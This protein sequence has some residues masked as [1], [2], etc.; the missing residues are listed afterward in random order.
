[1]ESSQ[2]FDTAQSWTLNY[3]RGCRTMKYTLKRDE[4]YFLC[5]GCSVIISNFFQNTPS[6]Y[7]KNTCWKCSAEGYE[8]TYSANYC[9]W[10]CSIPDCFNCGSPSPMQ[11]IMPDISCENCQAVKCPD[12]GS[13]QLDKEVSILNSEGKS[14]LLKCRDIECTGSVQMFCQ[15]IKILHLKLISV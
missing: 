9:C 8:K 4:K 7:F 6:L 10:K 3:C 12:C 11:N 1:M 13:T 5:G 2:L 15:K 14:V